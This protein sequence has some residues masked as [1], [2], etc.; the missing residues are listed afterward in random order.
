MLLLKYMENTN[1][2]EFEN[3]PIEEK[4]KIIFQKKM[5]F[6]KRAAI[7]IV[8]M[9]GLVFA[10]VTAIKIR[11]EFIKDRLRYVKND[12]VGTPVVNNPDVPEDGMNSY[13]NTILQVSFSYPKDTKLIENISTQKNEGKVE[14]TYSK[15]AS[16][17]LVN[18]YKF[19][20]TVFSTQ[21]R[22]LN[23]FVN[24][25]LEGMKSTCPDNATF[26]NIT[27]TNLNGYDALTFQVDYCSGYYRNYY[28]NFGGKFFEVSKY[29]KGDVG[30]RQQYEISTEE[31]LKTLKFLPKRFDVSE[32]LKEVKDES[33]GI[34]FE[35][36]SKL[37]TTCNIPLPTDSYYRVILSMCEENDQDNG[38]FIALAR[39]DKVT[40]FDSFINMEKRKLSD[41]YF[42]AKGYPPT[43]KEEIIEVSGKYAIKLSG[44]SWKY[45]EYTFID[46]G[47]TP[48]RRDETI[49]LI[50]TRDNNVKLG[51]TIENIIKS[52]KFSQ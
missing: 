48:Q 12:P 25:R 31:I 9:I 36:P 38:I 6:L 42:A 37:S 29:F 4:E 19:S 17:E 15:D 5:R 39:T 30:F 49:A 7:G 45:A 32:Y 51:T 11:Q 2:L 28:V 21:V 34:T 40:N 33:S 35:Y 41:D 1:S 43:T 52:I 18:G 13:E 8:F 10:V 44:Y 20:I 24:T 46:I 22:D 50:G 47:Q 14:V 23:Q 16:E 26:S 3:L 27:G